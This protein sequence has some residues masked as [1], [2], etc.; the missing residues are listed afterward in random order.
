MAVDFHPLCHFLRKLRIPIVGTRKFLRLVSVLI[1]NCRGVGKE[2]AEEYFFFKEKDP[3][4][5]KK[6]RILQGTF[7]CTLELVY[8]L[9]TR[10]LYG[11]FLCIVR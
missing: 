5:C 2:L 11:S 6:D 8:V 9:Q 1:Y 3:F 10:I 7:L 4:L